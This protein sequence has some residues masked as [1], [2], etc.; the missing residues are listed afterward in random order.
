MYYLL[1]GKPYL[2]RR[3]NAKV[4]QI[5]G[6]EK[7]L[8]IVLIGVMA[9]C[10][11]MMSGENSADGGVSPRVVVADTVLVDTVGD[12]LSGHPFVMSVGNAAES[13]VPSRVVVADTVLVDTVGGALSDRIPDVEMVD[14]STRFD[15]KQLILPAALV[16]V[17][18]LGL[19]PA[20]KDVNR[21]IR[22]GVA[23]MRDGHYFRAD[24]YLQYLPVV[25]T[26]GLSLLGAKARHS[27]L[28]RTFLIATSY[29]TMGILV[30]GLKYTIREPRP[31]GGSNSF[32][33]G[34]TA[35][36]F[37]GAEL[38]RMEYKDASVWYGVG[39]YVVASGIGVLRVWNERHWATDVLAG[40]GIGI[41]SARVAYWLLPFERRLFGLDKK[42]NASDMVAVP[43]YS[44]GDRT[45]GASLALTF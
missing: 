20:V 24:D 26:Y 13:G 21:D 45:F 34:H 5:M 44:P 37:M 11:F 36:A 12:A 17:G 30:N 43:Y 3:N 14:K 15:A 22:D 40:A 6:L 4:N 35:T 9:M 41:L 18:S 42:K 23:D 10:P 25:S 27:Y 28:D 8:S 2:C 29:L 32:P 16:A 39:A 38:V 19:I 33:S 31:N 1:F 7:I